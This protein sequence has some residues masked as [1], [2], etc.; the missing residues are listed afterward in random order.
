M[1]NTQ[2]KVHMHSSNILCE[3]IVYDAWY[4]VFI[5]QSIN[6]STTAEEAQKPFLNINIIS[7]S[8]FL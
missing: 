8:L 3:L 7:Y 1:W 2:R 4:L 6:I 5:R